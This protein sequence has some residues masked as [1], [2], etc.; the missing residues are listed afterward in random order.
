MSRN[1]TLEESSTPSVS[2][3]PLASV[4]TPEELTALKAHDV[5]LNHFDE[6]KVVVP[7][8]AE[9]QFSN[10]GFEAL[11]FGL[12]KLD[13]LEGSL[14]SLSNEIEA[15]QNKWE[16][17]MH[18]QQKLA[19]LPSDKAS[20]TITDEMRKDLDA[21]KSFGFDFV[22]ADTKEISAERLSSM[23]AEIDSRKSKVQ[24]DI[25]MKFISVQMM[26][27]K[28]NSLTESLKLIERQQARLMGTIANNMGKR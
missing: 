7:H 21:L 28:V 3:P 1:I 18:L 8:L 10:L 9:R 11:Q 22:S 26:T 2:L 15:M 16:A 25:Q 27:Q 13:Q 6:R 5:G 20:H 4:S 12:A 19:K 17:V 14:G 23:K 24:T